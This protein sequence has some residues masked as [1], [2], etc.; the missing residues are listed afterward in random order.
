MGSMVPGDLEEVIE[1]VLAESFD[2]RVDESEDGEG[3]VL[4]VDSVEL[5][6]EVAELMLEREEAIAHQ[7]KAISLD[8]RPFLNHL[9]LRLQP[10]VIMLKCSTRQPNNWLIM[11]H[12][13]ELG[14]LDDL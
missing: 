3:V 1:V 11:D 10:V 6:S 14:H 12:L 2:F 7:V 8:K 13:I 9:L 5:L 4:G